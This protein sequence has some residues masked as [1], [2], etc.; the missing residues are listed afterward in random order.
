MILA[1]VGA[2]AG[3]EG[4]AEILVAEITSPRAEAM[5]TTSRYILDINPGFQIFETHIPLIFCDE[6]NLPSIIDVQL[7]SQVFR[8]PSLPEFWAGAS[9][10]HTCMSAPA[11]M[12]I[13]EVG[14]YL[15]PLLSSF[16]ALQGRRGGRGRGRGR[17]RF[18]DSSDAPAE[19]ELRSAGPSE[20]GRRGR[21]RRGRDR[22]PVPES[23][24]GR[25]HSNTGDSA[26]LP[27]PFF[28]M[29]VLTL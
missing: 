5:Q 3:G 11:Q 13:H 12:Q 19:R 22:Q 25:L 1:G 2:E 16:F 20:S 23:S 18:D 21:G 8:A 17:G 7:N 6:I 24:G 4:E 14:L 28:Y 9:I 27:I 15:M 10:C 29:C 26:S